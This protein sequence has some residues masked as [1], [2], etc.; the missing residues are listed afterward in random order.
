M[1]LEAAPKTVGNEGR[2]M[3]MQDTKYICE[4]LQTVP[5][6]IGYVVAKG[7][8]IFFKLKVIKLCLEKKT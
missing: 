6:K 3:M 2:I 7:Y 4:N 1:K 8:K 5:L